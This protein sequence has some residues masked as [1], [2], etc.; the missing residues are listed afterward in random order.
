MQHKLL[1]D[2]KADVLMLLDCCYA[3][4]AI[5]N[6]SEAGSMPLGVA[7]V[8]GAGG[9][10]EAVPLRGSYTFTENL[11][12]QFEAGSSQRQSIGEFYIQ[13]VRRAETWQALQPQGEWRMVKLPTILEL[14]RIYNPK[15]IFL[16]RQEGRKGAKQPES[17]ASSP[18]RAGGG[19]DQIVT[20]IQRYPGV[21]DR[22]LEL[23]S[24]ATSS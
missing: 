20:E 22:L 4:S 24:D 6:I 13:M 16:A 11:V 7:A 9:F 8:L 18:S 21:Q 19:V 1:V 2:V 15:S 12:A 23:S 3:Q 10:D 5:H 14:T 17:W